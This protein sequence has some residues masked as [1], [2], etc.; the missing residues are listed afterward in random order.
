MRIDVFHDIACP[1]CRIGKQHLQLALQQWE[2]TVDVHYHTFFLND[3][4]PPEGA[5]FRTYML[6]KGQ[7]MVTDVE[8]FFAAPRSMGEQVGITFN[9][10]Q[11]TKAP[12]TL[13]AHR[14]IALTPPATKPAMIDALYQAYFEDAQDI[15]DLDTLV[16]I[17][18]ALGLDEADI[19][20]RLL[21]NEAAEDVLT[22]AR[23]A[24]QMGV[25][26]V[27]LFVFDN[28]YALSGA[29]PPHVM[30]QVMQQTKETVK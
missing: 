27:P 11:I 3:G 4:I 16:A 12:N 26:G 15:G 5:D 10:E 30:L 28:T 8:Q 18:A 7:G 13:L 29:Q 24:Q 25:T 23:H 22:Q 2:G 17:A 9:F 6:A 19:R 20:S 1:W 14:L 21:G